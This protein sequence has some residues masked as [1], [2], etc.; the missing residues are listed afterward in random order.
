MQMFHPQRI[1]KPHAAEMLRC[2]MRNAGELERFFLREGIADFNR[3]VIMNA[4]DV[5]GICL[6]DIGAVLRHKNC[7]IGERYFLADAV[8]NNFHAALKLSRTNPHKSDAVAVRRIH[9]GLD[10]KDKAGKVIFIRAQ[11][12]WLL[13]G[14]ATGGGAISTKASSKFL[15]A[16]IVDGAAEENRRLACF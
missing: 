6:F 7:G 12:F 10:F 4:D 2:E 5:A 3:A 14:R 8:M 9:I 16:E 13:S 15:D 11:R 1:F